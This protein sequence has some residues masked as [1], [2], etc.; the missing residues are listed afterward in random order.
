MIGGA[1]A[2]PFDVGPR[3]AIRNPSL[4]ERFPYAL[5][6][7]ISAVLFLVGITTGFLFLKETL[8]TRAGHRDY[9]LILGQKLVDAVK[10]SVVKVGKLSHLRSESNGDERSSEREPLLKSA[11]DEETAPMGT[12]RTV[13]PPPTYRE[14]LNKQAIL[15]L[16]VYTF[17]ALHTMGYDQLLPVFMHHPKIG[18]PHSTPF[19]RDRP[20]NFSGGLGLDHLRIG[21]IS[22]VYGICGMAAQFILFPPVAR[23]FGVLNCMKVCVI[24]FPIAYFITPFTALLPTTQSQIAGIFAVMLLKC[25]AAIFV[26]PCTIILLTNAASSMRVLGTLNGF[27]T[28]FSAIGRAAG[29]K[30]KIQT[31]KDPFRRLPCLFSTSSDVDSPRF[32]VFWVFFI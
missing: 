19:N 4:L 29:A 7:I 17:L 15:N 25:G 32:K 6:N 11:Q 22:T 18:T 16:V 10:H 21:L 3:E 24:V 27:A 9:G 13:L 8:E 1:L 2:N 26:F 31:L 12:T 28:S 14:V 5:P 20:L 30:K 23:K